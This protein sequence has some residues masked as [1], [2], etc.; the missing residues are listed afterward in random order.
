MLPAVEGARVDLIATDV[1]AQWLA[2]AVSRP[3]RDQLDVCQIAA[4]HRAIPIDDLL[5][6]AVAHLRETAS[7]WA[8]G[9]IEPPVIVDSTTYEL[10][11]QSVTESGDALFG[12]VLESAGSFFP[13]LLYPKVYDTA[14]AE[15]LWGGSLPLSDWRSTLRRV[16]DFGTAR[17]WRGPR[18]A[19]DQVHV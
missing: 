19:R 4:G 7:G 8:G 1:A 18:H 17:D 13:A 12:R 3:V 11:V 6:T 14:R 15:A 5:D 2:R 10:F 16:I 9:Q